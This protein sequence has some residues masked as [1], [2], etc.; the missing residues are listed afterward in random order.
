MKIYVKCSDPFFVLFIRKKFRLMLIVIK[1]SDPVL[2]FFTFLNALK[3][4]Y[5]SFPV[6][7]GDW[8]FSTFITEHQ[9]PA[10]PINCKPEKERGLLLP[11]NMKIYVKCSNPFFVLFIREKF[12]LML[13]VI[14]R[15]DPVLNFFTFLTALKY[16]Y[17]NFPVQDGD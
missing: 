17:R 13:I 10:D 14:K 12:R 4:W 7:D 8:S 11:F 5:R 9:K 6:Q 1:R 3:Y 15:S 16:R 2:N